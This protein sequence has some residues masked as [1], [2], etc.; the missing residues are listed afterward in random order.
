MFSSI[1]NE[2]YK[3][4][5]DTIS[6]ELIFRSNDGLNDNGDNNNNRVKS[7]NPYEDSMSSWALKCLG[8]FSAGVAFG[9]GATL[10][11]FRSHENYKFTW[12]KNKGG[13]ILATQAFLYGSAIACS[14][15]GLG[16]WSFFTV[17]GIKSSQE[18]KIFMYKKLEPVAPSIFMTPD[19]IKEKDLL[20]TLDEEHEYKYLFKKYFGDW[21]DELEQDLQKEKEEFVK[22]HGGTV[23]DYVEKQIIVNEKGEEVLSEEDFNEIAEKK[24]RSLK[25]HFQ[26]LQLKYYHKLFK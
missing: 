11:F 21:N 26:Y 4:K 20:M 14:T 5:A 18:L 15:F 12:K 10:M 13:T 25:E 17:T 9:T 7:T 19:D 1:K 24:D 22:K 16:I 3:I 2:S 6:K 23:D 8:M